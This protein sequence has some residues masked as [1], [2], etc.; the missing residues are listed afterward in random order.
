VASL[1][2]IA[3]SLGV[4]VALVSKVLN[5]R[6]GT[7]GCSEKTRKAILAKA[8]QLRFRPNPL[9]VA[10]R[11]GR[12]GTVGVFVHP[13][14][15]P[16]SGLVESLLDGIAEACNRNRERIWLSFFKT[17]DEFGE[18]APSEAQHEVD[19]LL[20]A[21]VSHPELA[22]LLRGFRKQGVPVVSVCTRPVL[23]SIPN[24]FTDEEALGYLATRHLLERGCRR[25]AHV[26]RLPSRI[27]GYRRALRAHGLPFSPA[28]VRETKEFA[29]GEGGAAVRAWLAAGM[30]F[31]GVVAQSDNQALGAMYELLRHG[32][33]VPQEVKV[34]GIDNSP[35]CDLSP[36]ALSSVSQ[37]MQEVGR[38]AAE[39]LLDGIA[40]KRMSSCVVPPQ[41]IRRAS[42]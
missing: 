22:P 11:A 18:R 14:G 5:R 37:E 12:K 19:G 39:M 17:G 25:I 15:N 32:R 9:A 13:I 16:G 36:V 38:R 40:G 31:D 34:V 7:S 33:K 20:L 4:S 10:L 24:V 6:M 26:G 8:K 42:S 1:K 21:G 29:L 28:L 35:I 2:D 27:R 30:R 3:G 23:P 41:V